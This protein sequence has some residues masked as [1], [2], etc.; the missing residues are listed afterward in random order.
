MASGKDTRTAPT[1]KEAAPRLDRFGR[2]SVMIHPLIDLPSPGT[3]TAGAP[4][5]GA[6]M[7]ADRTP[8]PLCDIAA[9]YRSIQDEIEEAVLR[10]MRSGQVVL[11]PEVAAFEEDTAAF[12]RAAH[13]LG[14]ASGT[15]AISL[16]LHALDV[17]PGDEVILP[18][19]TF[20][21]T[22]GCVLRAGATPVF[23]DI[24]PLTFN[25]DP[26]AVEAKVSPR[27]R[28]VM[29]VH[30]F[31]QCADMT[32]IWDLADKHGLYVIEDAAQS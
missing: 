32:P 27:T 8:V 21:A 30:L 12:C 10:V 25:I 24:D 7:T 20:F 22:A 2:R 3:D 23:A 28:A 19:F 17:G 15:D 11:G 26:E 4:S 6:G 31:G 14:C 16:A 5:E 9:Q 29:P 1:R 18:P 13:A